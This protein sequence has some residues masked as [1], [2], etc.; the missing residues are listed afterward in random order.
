MLK[1]MLEAQEKEV[2]I[3]EILFKIEEILNSL[4]EIH[5][6]ILLSRSISQNS[7]IKTKPSTRILPFIDGNPVITL[8]L[9]LGPL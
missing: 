5:A 8:E 6:N 4:E 7:L 3:N 9:F 1:D 2:I